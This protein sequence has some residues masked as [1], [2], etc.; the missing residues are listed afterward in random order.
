[1]ELFRKIANLFQQ[2]VKHGDLKS[3][4]FVGFVIWVV[5][6]ILYWFGIESEQIGYFNDD[7]IYAISAK[8]LWL[9][10]G[11]EN[12]HLPT[13]PPQLRYPVGYPLLLSIVW[14]LIPTV[15]DVIFYQGFLTSILSILGLAVVFLY[16]T[17]VKKL[18][19][20]Y[21]GGIA[22]FS[23]LN[24][25]GLIYFTSV[26]SEGPYL[27]FS[28]LTLFW[29]EIYLREKDPEN[30][31]LKRWAWIG[32]LLFSIVSVHIRMIGV[33]L[34]GAIAVKLAFNREWQKTFIYVVVTV[35][36]T[37]LPW[38]AWLLFNHQNPSIPYS[39]ME[40]AHLSPI[41][42]NTVLSLTSDYGKGAPSVFENMNLIPQVSALFQ[43][44]WNAFFPILGNFLE[45]WLPQKTLR[46]EDPNIGFLMGIDFLK[47]LLMLG[48]GTY[49]ILI[50]V[51]RF[52]QIRKEGVAHLS[53][54]E[55]YLVFYWVCLL[56]WPYPESFP[57]FLIVVLPLMLFSLFRLLGDET[58]LSL[59]QWGPRW[60]QILAILFCLLGLGSLPFSL[61]SYYAVKIQPKFSPT[62][63]LWTEYRQAFQFIQ[64]HAEPEARVGT[65][66]APCLY[67]Y[68]QHQA[69]PIST[70]FLPLEPLTPANNTP[71][72]RRKFLIQGLNLYLDQLKA[73]HVIYLFQEPNNYG[74]SDSEEKNPLIQ[75]FLTYLPGRLK[76][77]FQSG[78]SHRIQIYQINPNGV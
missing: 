56:V 70:A 62:P 49:L 23:A 7:A 69:L 2:Q 6:F 28:F 73:D 54:D 51:H 68:T 17:F 42:R 60:R 30:K 74:A 77:V 33:V 55:L 78:Y 52:K 13:H 24:I 34:V 46:P 41:I 38:G 58:F 15:S 14:F 64:Q 18:K 3:I 40:M 39:S 65:F 63:S 72:N 43:G 48:F 22:L 8:S 32:T 21:A 37:I 12:L 20:F 19:P 4:F 76:P 47:F 35:C 57:R 71:E 66:Y 5:L 25:D 75:L 26:M 53:V 1:M 9:G 27:L 61:Y 36:S 16:F 11:Y 45:L 50:A 44:V 29:A 10:Q 67:L 31:R 59:A